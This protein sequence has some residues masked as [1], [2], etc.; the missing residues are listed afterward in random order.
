M[1]GNF[2]V[3]QSKLIDAKEKEI[4]LESTSD[5]NKAFNNFVK[6]R[7]GGHQEPLLDVIPKAMNK[8]IISTKKKNVDTHLDHKS[9]E[10]YRLCKSLGL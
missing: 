6:S 10:I 4:L 9:L 1:K 7:L 2:A 3:K 8:T 5:G